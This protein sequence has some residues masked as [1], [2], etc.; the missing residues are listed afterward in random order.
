MMNFQRHVVLILLFLCDFACSKRMIQSNPVRPALY[1]L[2]NASQ[3][4]ATQEKD[5]YISPLHKTWCFCSTDS[6]AA[7]S[8][9]ESAGS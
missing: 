3:F 6:R 4:D 2:S 7:V 9:G 1:V 5:R 8:T